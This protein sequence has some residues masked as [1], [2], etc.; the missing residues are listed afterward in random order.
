MSSDYYLLVRLAT[1]PT[2]T[3][4]DHD[5]FLHKNI[6]VNFVPYSKSPIDV[7]TRFACVT[8]L[9]ICVYGCVLGCV[10]ACKFRTLNANIIFFPTAGTELNCCLIQLPW[11]FMRIIKL[12]KHIRLTDNVIPFNQT[13]LLLTVNQ[14]L[15]DLLTFSL[16]YCWYVHCTPLCSCTK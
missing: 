9:V 13:V 5:P 2:L 7:L 3:Y 4:Y 11:T 1:T 6:I 8:D 14:L 12:F 16:G 15:S 10:F